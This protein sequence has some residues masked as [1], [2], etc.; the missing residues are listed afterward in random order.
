MVRATQ[1][2]AM[3]VYRGS[4]CANHV[5]TAIKMWNNYRLNMQDEYHNIALYAE[6]MTDQ[7]KRLK[8]LIESSSID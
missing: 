8:L 2:V 6:Q 1:V 3:L 4:G 5:D 7:Q